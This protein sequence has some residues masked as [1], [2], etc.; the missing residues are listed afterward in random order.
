MDCSIHG[1]RLHGSMDPSMVEGCM[2]GWMDRGRQAGCHPSMDQP[3]WHGWI[4][5]WQAAIHRSIQGGRLACQASL[6]SIHRGQAG[7]MD[8]WIDRGRLAWIHG[9]GRQLASLMDGSREAG[10]NAMDAWIDRRQPPSIH[11]S[12][13]G[14]SW[15]GW[16][17]RGRQA[18]ID[19]W[20]NASLDPSRPGS[21]IHASLPP[22]DGSRE[23]ACLPL[24]WI[25]RCQ[26]ASLDGWIE[27][28]HAWILP[29]GRH[30]CCLPP[31]IWIEGGRLACLPRSREAGMPAWIAM[32]PSMP[33][34]L[35]R[36]MDP[37]MPACLDRS[38]H[39]GMPGC[40]DGS[41][42]AGW[43]RSI[44]PGRPAGMDG[45]IIQARLA[46]MDGSMR[47]AAWHGS[48]HRSRQAGS[49]DPWIHGACLP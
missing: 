27:G 38:I 17:D 11:G 3:A 23:A 29:R 34:W 36:S 21:W 43:H 22:L 42:E 13:Q 20:I 4:H 6:G 37:W 47:E 5:P 49:L 12:I 48:I 33:A 32:D 28:C 7:C 9:S 31:W 44:H 35:P 39:P 46:W 1:G 30:P 15:H 14:G 8:G 2:D 41:R 24:A 18:G 40:M 16:M 26:P 45:W 10:I 19:P 25:H